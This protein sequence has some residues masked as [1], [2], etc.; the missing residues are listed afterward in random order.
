MYKKKILKNGMRIVVVPIKGAPSTTVM[1][2]IEAGSEYEK[3]EK[4]GISHFLE[5]MFFKGTTNRP[6]SLHISKEFDGMG[7]YNNAF[8]SNEFTGY[9]GKAH[10]KFL[11]N[12]LDIISDM[13]L[14]PTF[15]GA[16]MEKEKGV[17]L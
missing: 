6:T 5:H 14:H 1:S 17:I 11:D 12:I 2:L 4:N 16:E 13:Y 3:K 15:P 9:Y 10:P 7:A 8:T